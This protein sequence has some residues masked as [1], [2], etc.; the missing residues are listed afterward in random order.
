MDKI[1]KEN[2]LDTWNK[3]LDDFFTKAQAATKDV[4]EIHKCKLE[5]QQMKDEI[6]NHIRSGY[7]L[8]DDS[9]IVISA[10]EIV[11]GNVD[12]DGTLKS[13]SNVIIRSHDIKVEGVGKNGAVTI[14]ANTIT[15]RTEDPGIDG[16]EAVV[17]DGASFSCLSS[18]ITINST[19]ANGV[20]YRD[21]NGSSSGIN[22]RS[23]TSI[24]INAALSI[25]DSGMK[26]TIKNRISN[27]ETA[28]SDIEKK[29][30]EQ[31][32][33]TNDIIK[34]IKDSLDTKDKWLESDELSNANV[35]AID[36]LIGLVEDKASA[37][38]GQVRNYLKTMAELAE[39]KRRVDALN[40]I[41]SKLKAAN[42]YNE[43][44]TGASLSLNGESIVISTK[45]GDG[46]TRENKGAGVYF[47]QVKAI[48]INAKDPQGSLMKDSYVN[49]ET[50]N[51]NLITNASIRDER[52]KP[53]HLDTAEG[54]IMVNSKNITVTAYDYDAPEKDTDSP[55]KMKQLAPE[56]K[57]TIGANSIDLNT[58]DQEGKAAG[59]MDINSK[60]ITIQSVNKPKDDG[61]GGGNN[62]DKTELTDEGTTMIFSKKIRIGGEKVKSETKAEKVLVTAKKVVAEGDEETDIMQGNEKKNFIMLKANKLNAKNPDAQVFESSKHD[63]SGDINV[64]KEANIKTGTIGDLTVKASLKSPNQSDSGGAPLS[65]STDKA[66]NIDEE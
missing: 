11:I 20:F 59:T 39:M 3:K 19:L 53:L 57:I 63:F 26:N 13:A 33:A 46:N 47:D 40:Y 18:S 65:V 9:R 10:P 32:K 2:I 66:E 24:S 23:D 51:I 22:L 27:I 48:D 31:Q 37:L 50:Q 7:F 29:V 55:Y 52:E 25:D 34:D 6:Y 36:T 1:K 16:V 42:E 64:S 54:S 21:E 15:N 44:T 8:H 45:D 14:R 41:K 35:A 30:N 60:S 38:M 62:N 5:V 17:Y 49:I 61:N 43:N 4:E 12:K 58:A 56:G 28:T